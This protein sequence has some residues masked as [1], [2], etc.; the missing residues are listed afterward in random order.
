MAAKTVQEGQAYG[1]LATPTK[2][3]YTFDGWYTAKSGGAKV[4]SSTKAGTTNVT[5]YA[6]WKVNTYTVNFDKN[7]G[8][9]PSVKSIQVAYGQSYGKL[10]TVKRKGYTFSG[11]YTAKSGGTKISEK[12]TMGAGN[13]TVYAH[14]KKVSKPKT[15]SISSLK[16]GK[17]SFTVS[18]KK[19][20][21]AKGYEIRYSTNSKLKSAK[22]VTTKSTKATIK[23]LKKNKKYYVQVRASKLDSMNKKVYGSWSK[24]KNVKTK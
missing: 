12:T 10:A 2:T 3:G 11:W 19:V 13:V 17:K 14:W 9:N 1:T 22:T 18:Y 21:D 20:K 4:S 6:H 7:G 15:T 16:K 24:T 23:K 8:S 5:L